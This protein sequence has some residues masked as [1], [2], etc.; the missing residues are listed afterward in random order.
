MSKYKEHSKNNF[1][2]LAMAFGKVRALIRPLGTFSHAKAHGR[3][4]I[5][6]AFSRLFLQMGEGA[7]RV[8]SFKETAGMR[9]LEA[10]QNHHAFEA[11]N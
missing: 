4:P 1:I 11:V 3:R 9:A 8:R 7:Q 10:T 5:K 6:S 2:I